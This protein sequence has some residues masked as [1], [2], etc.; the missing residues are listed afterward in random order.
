MDVQC[1]VLVWTLN[2]R[3]MRGAFP[4]MEVL[5]VLAI[6]LLLRVIGGEV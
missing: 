4:E 3:V 1:G 2:E 6:A 5:E